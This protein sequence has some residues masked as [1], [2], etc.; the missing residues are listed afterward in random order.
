MDGVALYNR[1]FSWMN[2]GVININA[3]YLYETYYNIVQNNFTTNLERP[4]SYYFG[5]QELWLPKRE[6]KP[7][8]DIY[9]KVW[10]DGDNP[11]TDDSA[12]WIMEGCY[13]MRV[14]SEVLPYYADD[15][16]IFTEGLE[17]PKQGTHF[18]R[19]SGSFCFDQ[20]GGIEISTVVLFFNGFIFK[21]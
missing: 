14:D 9:R 19:Y 10:A 17:Y 21:V 11:E 20:N 18:T 6:A 16:Y 8:S 13:F 3:Y 4:V 15:G 5:E 1:F 7:T 12:T 2:P